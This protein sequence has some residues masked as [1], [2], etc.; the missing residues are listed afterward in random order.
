MKRLQ[1]L[2][3]L[4]HPCPGKFIF[5]IPRCP[6]AWAPILSDVAQNCHLGNQDREFCFLDEADSGS[7]L[8]TEIPEKLAAVED[9]DRFVGISVDIEVLE[10]KKGHILTTILFETDWPS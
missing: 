10:I 9:L 2:P 3:I 7:L 6:W 4:L 5:I 8:K 1:C